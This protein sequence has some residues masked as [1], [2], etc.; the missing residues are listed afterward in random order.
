[1]GHPPLDPGGDPGG[2]DPINR[3]KG[4][5]R[6]LF[7]KKPKCAALF[8]DKRNALKQLDLAIV[9]PPGTFSPMVPGSVPAYSILVNHPHGAVYSSGNILLGP[10]F[11]DQSLGAQ[12]TI[13]IHEL[14]HQAYNTGEPPIT[15]PAC[16]AHRRRENAGIVAACATQMP[17][18]P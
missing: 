15:S 3:L 4:N 12:E 10:K 9:Y 18:K 2:G 17:S 8:G 1:M 13:L 6:E 16:Q 7:E 14:R 5:V 11:F